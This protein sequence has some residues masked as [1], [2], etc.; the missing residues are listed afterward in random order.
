MSAYRIHE[1]GVVIP[2]GWCDQTM[3]VFRLAEAGGG[4]DAAL[5][6]TRDR[7]TPLTEVAEYAE[8]QQEAFKHQFPGY[9][10]L[11]RQDA[12]LDGLPA[13]VLDYKWR[14]Q[15]VTL[16]QRQAMVRLDEAMLIFTLSARASEFDRHVAAWDSLLASFKRELPPEAQPTPAPSLMGTAVLSHVFALSTQT[17][18][19][20]VYPDAEVAAAAI[21]GLEVTQGHWVFFSSDGTPLQPAFT[22]RNRLGLLRSHSGRYELQ[23]DPDSAGGPLD[24]RLNQVVAVHGCA[25]LNTLDEITRHLSEYR[26]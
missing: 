13:I 2:E 26:V 9:R 7:D 11:S 23:P 20:H 5:L 1:G 17:R 12:E 6:I 8:A 3:N 22:L 18:T 25:P 14:S 24:L 15:N 16:R 10:A 21:P 4:K 19:L